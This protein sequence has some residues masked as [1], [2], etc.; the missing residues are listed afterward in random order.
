[1]TTSAVYTF[2]A[3]DLE[4]TMYK[5]DDKFEITTL[6]TYLNW[7]GFSD[8]QNLKFIEDFGKYAE[9]VT[10]QVVKFPTYITL[11]FPIPYSSKLEIVQLNKP[12]ITDVEEL[13]IQ[14]QK[15]QEIIQ[16]KNDKMDQ[17]LHNLENP[18]LTD[19]MR[20]NIVQE[21]DN[22]FILS[23]ERDDYDEYDE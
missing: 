19:I 21:L 13:R 16:E 5:K 4:I 17:V 3:G 6:Y 9:S 22:C 7:S 15:L 8:L 23:Y 2:T 20:E 1:M 11:S 12:N 18:V 10:I 14:I